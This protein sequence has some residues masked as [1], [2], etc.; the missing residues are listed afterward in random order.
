MNDEERATDPAGNGPPGGPVE[1]AAVEEIPPGELAARL[2]ATQE[3]LL[4][5]L[6]DLENH[7]RRAGVELANTRAEA[8]NEVLR[9]LVD[10]ADSAGRGVAAIADRHDDP[11][12]Q[13]LTALAEQI[14]AVMRRHG[15]ERIGTVGEPFDPGRHEAVG[16]LDVPGLPDGAVAAV[17]RQGYAAGGRLLRPAEVVVARAPV[18]DG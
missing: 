8:T 7:R 4:R 6:A 13:G 14:D 5:A 3:R 15:V 12:A 11:V 10:V 17:T 16:V 9:S 2:E 1:E 18:A